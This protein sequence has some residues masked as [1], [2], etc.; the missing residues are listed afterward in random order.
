[1]HHTLPARLDS[2]RTGYRRAG[3]KTHVDRYENLA[4]AHAGG[5]AMAKAKAMHHTLPARL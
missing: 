3:S 4:T 1:M 5:M 2:V